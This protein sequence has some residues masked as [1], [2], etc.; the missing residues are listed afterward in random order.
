MNSFVDFLFDIFESPTL[1]RK[2]K[3]AVFIIFTYLLIFKVNILAIFQLSFNS[4][5]SQYGIGT[6]LNRF[7]R[8]NL[9]NLRGKH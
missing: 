2:S 5:R 1:C 8:G 7:W 4:F 6:E 9:I 3:T